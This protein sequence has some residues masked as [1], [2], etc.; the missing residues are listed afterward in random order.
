MARDADSIRDRATRRDD[1]PAGRAGT[2]DLAH[3]L[4]RPAGHVA[5]QALVL[6][7]SFSWAVGTILY[8]DAALPVGPIA[9]NAGDLATDRAP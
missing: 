1:S 2:A 4:S 3:E 8:R 6:L 9:F 7:G 5:W